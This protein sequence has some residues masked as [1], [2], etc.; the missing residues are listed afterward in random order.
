VI[1]THLL[2]TIDVLIKQLSQEII[3]IVA[4]QYSDMISVNLK[5]WF[6]GAKL[7]VTALNPACGIDLYTDQDG[8]K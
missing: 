3:K 1:R 7:P 6:S 2:P 4:Q 5:D 8:L